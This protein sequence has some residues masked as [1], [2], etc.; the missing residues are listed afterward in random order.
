MAQSDSL[1]T[2]AQE[3]LTHMDMS[4]R[5]GVHLQKGMNFRLGK[6]YSVILMSV[7]PN[8]PYR[9]Q[10][11]DDG[12]TL[13]Y[14]GHDQPAVRGGP[15][16]KSVDQPEKYAGGSLTENGKFLQAALDC[17]S[18]SRTPELVRVYE[19]LRAGIW[20]YNGV[21]QLIDAWKEHDGRRTV[22]KFKLAA[23]DFEIN[24]DSVERIDL[25]HNRIIPS[26]VKQEVWKRD[27][28]RCVQCGAIDNLHFDHIL[29]FSRGGTSLDVKNIQLLCVRHNLSKGARL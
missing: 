26:H 6:S 16:P 12:R 17:R 10:V 19:K 3:I 8:A 21:F 1:I 29:P 9:D 2:M 5:E 18:G 25:D 20:S 24:L 11:L 15:D 23:T 13:V 7:R 14:E 28:G 22:F 27:K 4:R